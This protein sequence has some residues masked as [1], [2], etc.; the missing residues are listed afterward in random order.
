MAD[1]KLS[2][3]L[4]AAIQRSV[5]DALKRA[6]LDSVLSDEVVWEEI[7]DCLKNEFGTPQCYMDFDSG[8]A[9]IL[10][11]FHNFD[12]T[13]VG[14]PEITTDDSTKEVVDDQVRAIDAFIAKLQSAKLALLNGGS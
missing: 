1:L 6:V 5:V 10:F 8:A 7:E 11:G 9:R 12:F 3:A 4:A 2:S 14:E 13:L